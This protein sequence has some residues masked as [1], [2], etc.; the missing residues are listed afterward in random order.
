MAK[1]TP[2]P[3]KITIHDEIGQRWEV[4]GQD[5]LWEEVLELTKN[6]TQDATLPLS[7]ILSKRGWGWWSCFKTQDDWM[8]G[9][10]I[11]PP[12]HTAL[13]DVDENNLG[14]MLL[15]FGGYIAFLETQVGLLAGRRNALGEAYKAAIAV[16]TAGIE[17]K[18]SEKA[19]EAQVL[20]ESETLRQTK[21]LFIETDMLYESARGLCNSYTKCWETVSRL[22][23]IQTSERELQ[24]RRTI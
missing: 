17:D 4:D 7:L 22:V 9:L 14:Q 11:P 23:T 24:P 20:S 12:D 13:D 1:K 8:A 19:K 15:K 10:G 3:D 6:G 16:H 2:L 18:L 21:R 5:D